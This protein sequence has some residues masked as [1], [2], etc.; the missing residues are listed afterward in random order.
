M[1]KLECYG[2]ILDVKDIQTIMRIGRRQAYDLVSSGT[3]PSIR[4]GKRRI[5]ILKSAFIQWLE[6]Q[7]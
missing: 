5:K 4:I 7:D 6:K 1:K 3:I 2:D